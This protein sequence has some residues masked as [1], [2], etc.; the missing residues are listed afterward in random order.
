[1]QNKLAK[2][3]FSTRLTGILFIVFAAAMATGTFLDA[4]QETSPTPYTRNLIYNAWWFEAIMVFFV[5][6]FVGNIFRFK[7]HKKGKWSTL[8]LHL[9]FIFILL[10][11]FITRYISFEGMMAIREGATEN[12]FLSQKTYITTY[13]DGD[14]QIDGVAQRLP[15]EKEVDFSARL[16]NDFKIE[17]KYDQQPVTIELEKFIKGAEEDIIPDE[18][19]EKYLKMV[20]AGGGA[21][22]NH[23]LKV[24]EVQSI[25]NILFALNK[26]TDGAIN[27]TYNNDALTIQSPFEGEYMV[28]ATM[29]QG[30]LVKDSLQP[31]ILRSR[32]VIGDMQMVFPKPVVKGV[33]DIVQKSKILKNDEDGVVLKV[34]TK[35]ETQRIGLLGGKGMNNAFK[36]VSVGGLDF[37]FKY[38]S[39]VV[40]LPFAIKLNDFEAER[41]PGTENGYSAYSSQVTVIDEK[42]SSYDYKIFMNN[43]LDHGGYRFFQSSFDPDE[44]GTILSV[45][46]DYWGSLITY[47]GYFLLYYG[48]MAIL[49]AKGSRFGDLKKQLEKVKAKKAKLLGVF[50]LCFG[51]NSFAQTHSEDDGHNHNSKPTQ[52]QIDSVLAANITPKEHADAFGHLVIQDLSGRMM[53]VNTYASE[54]LRKLSKNDSYGDFDANQV[55][56]SIQES[57]MLWYNVPIIYLAKKKADSIRHIIGVDESEKYVALAD[58]FTERGDYKLAPYL[59]EAYKTTTPNGFQKEFKEADQRVNLLYNTVEG[60]SL[61]IFP[62]PNDENNKWISAFDYKNDTHKIQD[63]LYGN[64]IKNGFKMYLYTLNTAKQSGDFSEATKL[65]DAFKKTQHQYGAE[66]MLTDK[67][68]S[69]EILYNKYDIFKKLFSWYLY[70]GSL[71]FVLLIVQIFKE[72]SK[73]LDITITVFKAIIFVLFILHTLGLITRWYISGHAPWSDAYES[74]IYVAWSTMLFGFIVGMSKKKVKINKGD[75]SGIVLAV[76]GKRNTSNLTIAAGA[77]VTAMLLMIA[78]WNWM[79]PA[80]ANL[81][82]VLNSYW[83]MIHVAVIVASYGPFTLGMILGVVVLFL[84]IFTTEKNKIKMDLNIKE[85]TIINEMALTVGLV[86]LT[87]GNFLGGMWANESWGRYWG[88]DPKETWALI[89]IMV[90][91]FVIHMRLIPGLRGRWFFNLMSIVAF[92]SIIFTYFGVN[93]YLSGLHSYQSGQQIASFNAIAIAISIIALLG[94]LA[95]RGYAKHYKK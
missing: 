47:I 22:H 30:A 58:F 81:Q 29:A 90:Y 31:L 43:I 11:A 37:A 65:L 85:L 7:L 42:E 12:S 19:G 38:G 68:I 52:A 20:E 18:K 80:I 46:H 77:F 75:I 71:L 78:H 91:A 63:S 5:I 3:L 59:D 53:P 57:P 79:D 10:G 16:E 92:S 73:A 93:F 25:H 44:K 54:M 83:L 45:N 36:Q 41:Y 40:E 27:I 15:L 56:L 55:F 24:G 74:M 6:N 4:G 34:T 62:I 66:V 26:P 88:W 70:T 8:V 21:P 14:Y 28:M 69:T 82:P 51:L 89:S 67:K 50:I 48:L 13:I 76:L 2:I 17:T 35:G 33:F 9:S 32:Y 39:K 60:M 87:I 1:M 86:M 23:F 94:V 49:F 95:Y 61:K 84:M 72:K 64:F